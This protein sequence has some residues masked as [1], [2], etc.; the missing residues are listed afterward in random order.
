M[1]QE[2]VIELEISN[3]HVTVTTGQNS[4]NDKIPEFPSHSKADTP[5]QLVNQAKFYGREGE[6]L[7]QPYP[8]DRLQ[9]QGYQQSQ[10][11]QQRQQQQ[12]QIQHQPGMLTTKVSSQHNSLPLIIRVAK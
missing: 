9:W 6:G 8:V 2:T 3:I 1:F 4:Q 12:Q 5:Q 7:A 11:Q 10:Q